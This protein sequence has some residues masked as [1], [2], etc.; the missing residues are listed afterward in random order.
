[1]FLRNN[2]EKEKLKYENKLKHER[3]MMDIKDKYMGTVSVEKKMFQYSKLLATVILAITLIINCFFYFYLVPKSGALSV[4]DSAFTTL[5][6]V[7]E[8]WNGGTVLFFCGYFAKSL[9]E[10][11]WEKETI[12]KSESE[13]SQSKG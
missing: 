11:K 10:T 13:D 9:F 12:K 2:Y 5:G 1:M 8:T 6:T 4:T 7:L 3:E